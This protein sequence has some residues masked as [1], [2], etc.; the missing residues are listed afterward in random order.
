MAAYTL[1]VLSLLFIYA[2][3]VWGRYYE[4][5]KLERQVSNIPGR[6]PLCY[7]NVTNCQSYIDHDD[8]I[9]SSDSPFFGWTSMHCQASC[10]VCQGGPTTLPP[11]CMDELDYCDTFDIPKA[12]S[13]FPKWASEKCRRT[14]N[15]CQVLEPPKV[16]S[17]TV[18]GPTM[19]PLMSRK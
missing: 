17:P 18:V 15:V 9:C 6:N 8:T 2:T 14:C 3:L 12:C 1:Q 13:D 10:G 19:L 4:A 7:D 5:E 11:I 16:G